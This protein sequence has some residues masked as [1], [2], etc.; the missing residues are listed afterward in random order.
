L[1]SSIGFDPSC[2][3]LHSNKLTT[4]NAM[5]ATPRAAPRPIVAPLLELDFLASGAQDPVEEVPGDVLLEEEPGDVLV[6]VGKT[7]GGIAFASWV[8]S[9]ELQQVAFELP[10]HCPVN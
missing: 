10:Q 8:P 2:V 9:F 3:F 6:E 7:Y 4:A 1:S 5:T